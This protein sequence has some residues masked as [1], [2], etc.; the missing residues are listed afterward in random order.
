MRIRDFLAAAGAAA[1]ITA[2]ANGPQATVVAMACV[3]VV[4][5]VRVFAWATR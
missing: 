3:A 1:V 5:F 4:G 2:T